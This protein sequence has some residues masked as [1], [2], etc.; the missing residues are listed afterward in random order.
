MDLDLE[1]LS[2]KDV[3]VLGL[4]SE[5]NNSECGLFIISSDILDF[6]IT[7]LDDYIKTVDNYLNMSCLLPDSL[8]AYNC[9]VKGVQ[10]K[11]CFSDCLET[12]KLEKLEEQLEK[13]LQENEED[14]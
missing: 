4:S 10:I 9:R 12:I 11:Q 13:Q 3:H 8:K 5:L 2:S 7:L 1:S 6:M 14:I